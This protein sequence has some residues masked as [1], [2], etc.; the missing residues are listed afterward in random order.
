MQT[1]S[2]SRAWLVALALSAGA[3]QPLVGQSSPC[4][5]DSLAASRIC[6]AGADALTAFLPVEGALVGG[7]N[8][9]PGTAAAIGKFGHLRL[10]AR[11]GLA[12]VTIP[13]ASYD[14]STDTVKAD[15]RLIVPL[16]RFDL[17]LGVFSK[18]LALGTVGVDLLGSAVV[19]PTGATSRIAVD[20]NART[21]GGMALGLGFGFRAALQMSG[22]RPTVSLNVMKRDMPAIRFGNLAAGDRLSA[23]T[24]LSAT[25]VRLLVGGRAGLL[26]LSGGGGMDL[27][28][29]NGTVTYADSA[30]VDSTVAVPLST[31]RIMATASAAIDVGPV[32]LSME[33]G[34][35]VGKQTKL[36]TYFQKNDPSAG[37]FF[38]GLGA[39][40][41][42]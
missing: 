7:G 22:A 19:I 24:T 20:D 13:E 18:K 29:G 33:G 30:G 16:P 21:L 38:G 4:P 17:A 32:T 28:K 6:Q 39:A 36:A 42:F 12:S 40:F 35:Q 8:P 25:T 14:G 34:F 2:S 31:S 37:H 23:A 9:V 15:K 1:A 11:V 5:A 3:G 10:T 41:R 26:T 27:Y